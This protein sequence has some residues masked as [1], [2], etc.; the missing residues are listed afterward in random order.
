MNHF[1]PHEWSIPLYVTD[2]SKSRSSSRL[3][4]ASYMAGMEH[5]PDFLTPE[6]FQQLLD[7]AQPA[8]VEF[9]HAQDRFLPD[10]RASAFPRSFWQQVDEDLDAYARLLREQCAQGE[11]GG[12][13]GAQ[14]A[15]PPPGL[16]VPVTRKVSSRTRKIRANPSN[17]AGLK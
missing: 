7:D 5:N 1:D 6:R 16:Y 13:G 11:A 3:A 15:T 14:P 12:G 17:I 8:E 9:R 2:P 10:N 4:R